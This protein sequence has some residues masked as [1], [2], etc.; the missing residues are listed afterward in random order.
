[1]GAG[2]GLRLLE[3]KLAHP[4]HVVHICQIINVEILG[5]R[6]FYEHN[7]RTS[8]V[9]KQLQILN[10]VIAVFLLSASVSSESHGGG[11]GEESLPSL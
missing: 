5:L 11:G 2:A 8:F 1:M 10:E 4:R 7:L 9:H 6:E 3:Q